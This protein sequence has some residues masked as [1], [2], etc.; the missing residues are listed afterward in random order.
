MITEKDLE[1]QDTFFKYGRG[2]SYEGYWFDGCFDC[3]LKISEKGISFFLHNEVDGEEWHLRTV[4]SL[5]DLQLLYN[6][7]FIKSNFK[8]SINKR[9]Y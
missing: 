4:E 1:N 5:E 7:I 3:G 6:T 8:M 2:D 9:F